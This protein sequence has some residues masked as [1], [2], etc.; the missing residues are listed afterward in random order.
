[1][2][3][4]DLVNMIISKIDDLKDDITKSLDRHEVKIDL[5]TEKLNE[6]EVKANSVLASHETDINNL[7]NKVE[8]LESEKGTTSNI[9]SK[10]VG[11]DA[12]TLIFRFILTAFML[13]V[14]LKTDVV[15][16]SSDIVFGG[17]SPTAITDT[18]KKK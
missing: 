2:A 6:F 11:S 18:L 4:K 5:Q 15:K 10:I 12:M 7:K 16:Q 1:M 17:K 14:G 9:I 3:D 8:K 13:L